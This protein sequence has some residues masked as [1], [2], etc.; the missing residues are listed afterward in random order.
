MEPLGNC[1]CKKSQSKRLGHGLP[2]AGP[3]GLA[4]YTLSPKPLSPINPKPYKPKAL[5]S[6]P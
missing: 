2:V 1:R 3:I 5:N 4:P 6:K